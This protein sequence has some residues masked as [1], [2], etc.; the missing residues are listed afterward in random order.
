MITSF[1]NKPIASVYSKSSTKSEVNTQILYGEKFK[2]IS[3]KKGWVKIKTYFDNYTGFIKIDRFITDYNPTHKIYL[4]KSTIFKK[5]NKN[6]LKLKNIYIFQV[7]LK[8]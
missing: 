6:L 8:F 3:K 7:K 1:L 4:T 5:K 2:I